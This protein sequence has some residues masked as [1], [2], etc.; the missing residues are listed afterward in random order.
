MN[1][2]RFFSIL[3]VLSLLVA[4]VLALRTA[5]ATSAVV[6]AGHDMT[7][8]WL[9]HPDALAQP[10]SL[11]NLDDYWLRHPGKVADD[12]ALS[13]PDT[14][15]RAN[16]TANLDDYWLRHPGVQAQLASAPDLSD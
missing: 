7:D 4:G 16:S 6:A 13:Q 8:Y 11:P 1:T 12:Y 9:R 5:V 2:R 10:A 3:V 15:V 14:A